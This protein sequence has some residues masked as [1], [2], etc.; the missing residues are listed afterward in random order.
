MGMGKG[1]DK[2]KGR[3]VG[4]AWTGAEF[5]QAME[6][7]LTLFLFFYLPNL[8]SNSVILFLPSYYKIHN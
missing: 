3:D 5:S 6:L 4:K 7:C 8:E 1:M 2:G